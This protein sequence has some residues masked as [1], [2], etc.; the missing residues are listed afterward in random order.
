M[1]LRDASGKFVAS[2]ALAPK[3]KKAPAKKAAPVKKVAPK[4]KV[5]APKSVKSKGTKFGVPSIDVALLGRLSPFL[6]EAPVCVNFGRGMVKATLIYEDRTYYL[7][8]NEVSGGSPMKPN[9]R[10]YGYHSSWC[11]AD[12]RLNALKMNSIKHLLLPTIDSEIPILK[13]RILGYLPELNFATKT[14]HFG[15]K[16]LG[17]EN[18]IHLRDL[19]ELTLGSTDF[20]ESNL[21]VLTRFE[22]PGVLYLNGAAVDAQH[23]I[24]FIDAVLFTFALH[25][26]N[27]SKK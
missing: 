8:Q 5:V 1:I 10:D 6:H 11:L 19:A 14:V 2:E 22:K 4:K 20:W 13:E 15:C 23:V 21:P 18:L 27:A 25:T 7:F 26:H 17:I 24:N 16:N 3:V 12:G 9:P